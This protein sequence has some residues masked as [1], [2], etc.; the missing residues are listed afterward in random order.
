MKNIITKTLVL[1][2][3]FIAGAIFG[4]WNVE[5]AGI[6]EDNKEYIYCRTM[7]LNERGEDDIYIRVI[8]ELMDD[9]VDIAQSYSTSN[10]DNLL[11]ECLTTPEYIFD[12][13]KD[14]EMYIGWTRDYSGYR[15]YAVW[16]DSELPTTEWYQSRL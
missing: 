15:D 4:D 14:S 1:I 5:E 6:V 3:V 12:Y 11:R 9:M 16:Y 10:E 13:D 8:A 7:Y 2:A